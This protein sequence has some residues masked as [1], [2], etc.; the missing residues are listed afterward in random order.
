MKRKVDNGIMEGIF[1][2]G[3]SWY[4]LK[5]NVAWIL[6]VIYHQKWKLWR[7]PV[8]DLS[9][10][11]TVDELMYADVKILK[12]IQVKFFLEELAVLQ[13]DSILMTDISNQ[14]AQFIGCVRCCQ[15]R[16]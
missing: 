15:H 9:E 11:L 8:R 14:Q 7:L 5:R 13:N 16:V 2:A 4:K 1:T 6:V 3:S 12:C 10:G